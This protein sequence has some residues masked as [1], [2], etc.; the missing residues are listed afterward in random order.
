MFEK[1]RISCICG[2]YCIMYYYTNKN[3]ASLYNIK[4][5]IQENY[6]ITILYRARPKLYNLVATINDRY[7]I[8][9]IM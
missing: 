8:N 4:Y 9:N 2:G 5:F 3:Q 7:Y 1:Y 6:N